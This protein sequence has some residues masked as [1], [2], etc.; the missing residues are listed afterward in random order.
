MTETQVPSHSGAAADPVSRAHTLYLRIE[1]TRA[2]TAALLRDFQRLRRDFERATSPISREQMLE[3]SAYARLLARLESMPMIEQAKGVIMA[4]SSC[5]DAEAFDILRRASQRS[6]MPIREL[7][8]RIVAS[9]TGVPAPDKA[10]P[11]A[12]RP[13]TRNRRPLRSVAIVRAMT[14]RA[15]VAFVALAAV[16][17]LLAATGHDRPR[18]LA[19]PFLRKSSSRALTWSGASNCSQ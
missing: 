12:Q 15:T 11:V 9:T 3:R 1:E 10:E 13:G 18:W 8:A 7:A 17:T 6:N 5:G 4:H 14:R 16:D 19:K 2:Q